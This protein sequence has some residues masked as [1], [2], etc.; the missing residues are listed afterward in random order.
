[1]IEAFYYKFY[2]KECTVDYYNQIEI[3]SMELMVEP[4]KMQ[5]RLNHQRRVSL[6]TAEWTGLDSC[7]HF[8]IAPWFIKKQFS[9]FIFNVF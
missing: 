9:K 2:L 6:A 3:Q 4:V 7:N 8:V 5:V 1:M